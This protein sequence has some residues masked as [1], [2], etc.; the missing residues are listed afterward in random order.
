MKKLSK[1]RSLITFLTLFSLICL[2][3]SV[4]FAQFK[5]PE[6]LVFEQNEVGA[7]LEAS[8]LVGKAPLEVNFWNAS[9]GIPNY[10]IWNYGD[11]LVE[12]LKQG[13]PYWTNPYHY[14]RYPGEYS[15]TLT[16]WGKKGFDSIT[17]PNLIYVDAEFDHLPLK[18]EAAGSTFPGEDWSNAIDHDVWGVGSIVSAI[19]ADAWAVFSFRDGKAKNIY[20]IRLLTDTAM[21]HKFV[22]NLVQDFEIW[23]SL[24]NVDFVPAYLGTSAKIDG[25]W[26]LIEFAEPVQA[27]FVRL[28]LTSSRSENAHFRELAEFQILGTNLLA[29][30]LAESE[31]A[32][33]QPRSFGLGQN[34]P[35]P[36]NPHTVIPLEIPEPAN[37]SLAIYDLQGRLVRQLMD[38][39]SISGTFQQV[40]DGTNFA[41][42]PVA[43]GVYVYRLIATSAT[44][45]INLS[46]KMILM[47]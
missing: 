34:Y 21:D 30:P 42:E 37:V 28:T 13:W 38:Q 16:A 23:I 14:Y 39:V 45:R 2:A 40:W 1:K 3:G 31:V 32:N 41:N 8:L 26:D 22:T 5:L 29:K 15:V 35:N 20:K 46:K 25:Q 4:S 9:E 44:Q 43:A 12:Y 17:I 19:P 36:F 24:D 27:K 11:G 47:K 10:F 6:D 18:I 7:N 33:D